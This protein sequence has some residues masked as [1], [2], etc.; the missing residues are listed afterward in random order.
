M[1][2]TLLAYVLVQY[3]TLFLD[4]TLFDRTISNSKTVTVVEYWA[5]WNSSHEFQ[6]HGRL[7]RC[8]YYRVNI[9]DCN[10]IQQRNKITVVPT[11]VIYFNGQEH[12]RHEADLM[13]QLDVD[14]KDIQKEIEKIYYSKFQ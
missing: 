6:E 9:D 13:L 4:C 8:N 2:Y 3:N 10:D 7:K 5:S 12:H 14:Y 11:I 1:I